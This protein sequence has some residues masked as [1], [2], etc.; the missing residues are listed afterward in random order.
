MTVCTCACIF[1]SLVL[2]SSPLS[3]SVVFVVSPLPFESF[4]CV[5]AILYCF[6]SVTSV[7]VVNFV[8]SA[9]TTT[10]AMQFLSLF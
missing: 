8:P 1:H 6:V 4:L 10:S 5:V 9:S 7:D 2:S 3:L